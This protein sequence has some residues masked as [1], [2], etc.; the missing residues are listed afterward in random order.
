MYASQRDSVPDS[1]LPFWMTVVGQPVGVGKQEHAELTLPTVVE[2]AE[3]AYVEISNVAVCHP[4][5][6][7]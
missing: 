4:R 7:A 2:H 1:K 5:V 6:K 3:A